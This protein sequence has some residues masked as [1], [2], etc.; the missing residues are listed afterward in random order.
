[1]FSLWA[2]KKIYRDFIFLS[3]GDKIDQQRIW[4]E[5]YKY[6]DREFP[7]LVHFENCELMPKHKAKLVTF[8]FFLGFG[9]RFFRQ[10]GVKIMYCLQGLSNIYKVMLWIKKNA[11]SF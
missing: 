7:N 1:M 2:R 3:Y 6:L 5:G 4:Q 9:F 10:K 11:I 8:I